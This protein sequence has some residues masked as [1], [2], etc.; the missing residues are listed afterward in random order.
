MK[1]EKILISAIL[2]NNEAELMSFVQ[3]VFSVAKEFI[4][5]ICV[6]VN[7][8]SLHGEE[9]ASYKEKLI[10]TGATILEPG[11]NLGYFGAMNYAYKKKFTEGIHRY[12]IVSNTD[13][14]FDA[15]F[16]K[17]LNDYKL[18]DACIVAPR[19]ISSLSCNDQNPMY[20]ERPSRVK[21]YILSKIFSSLILTI[22][23]RVFNLVIRKL[24]GGKKASGVA[25]SAREIYA[26]HGALIIIS[27]NFFS[28]GGNLNYPMFLFCE[29]IFLAE[30]VRSLKGKIVY[31]PSLISYHEEHKTTGFIPSK[32]MR[33]FLSESH[34]FCYENMLK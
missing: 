2:Y 7:S 3:H 5:D 27:G 8:S 4:V 17:I 31:E 9:Y 25:V 1:N 22:M 30:E 13:L 21:F 11:S 14:S 33:Q 12:F 32:K 24:R 10:L 18:L 28:E 23:Q 15:D 29:E 26:A 19:I 20:V 34:L 16:F 6:T